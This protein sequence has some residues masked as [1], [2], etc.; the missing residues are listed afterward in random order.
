MEQNKFS[1][2]KLLLINN[3]S[4][5]KIFISEKNKYFIRNYNKSIHIKFLNKFRDI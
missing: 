2:C 4:N 3:D 5:S 1:Y